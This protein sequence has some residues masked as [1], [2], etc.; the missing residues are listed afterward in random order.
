MEADMKQYSQANRL[1]LTPGFSRVE[2]T[3]KEKNRLNGLFIR[4]RAVHR[5]ET[6]C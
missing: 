2:I 3:R 1:S 4:A 5:V 6:R